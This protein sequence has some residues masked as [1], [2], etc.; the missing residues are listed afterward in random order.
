ML[1]LALKLVSAVFTVVLLVTVTFWI[2]GKSIFANVLQ[3]YVVYT[4]ANF[5]NRATLYLY[6]P[7]RYKSVSIYTS[8]TPFSFR[9][10]SDG[11][12]ALKYPR[13]P[14]ITILDTNSRVQTV[15]D[16]EELFASTHSVLL[17]WSPDA[18][19][20]A[21]YTISNQNDATSA[22]ESVDLYV[23]DKLSRDLI[24][25]TPQNV[26]QA[27]DR[28]TAIWSNDGRLAITV[29][30]SVLEPEIF[31]WDGEQVMNLSQNPSGRDSVL[32]WSYDGQ[33]AFRSS[34]NS[35]D[36]M[37]IWDGSPNTTTF[38][39]LDVLINNTFFREARWTFVNASTVSNG[40]ASELLVW[41]GQSMITVSQ[42]PGS[43]HW[44]V[45]WSPDGW[46]A[47]V[48][49][50]IAGPLSSGTLYIHDENNHL[51]LTTAATYPL[52]WSE[53]GF[54][55]YC[56]AHDGLYLWSGQGNIHHIAS[57]GT[58]AQWQ[59]GQATGGCTSG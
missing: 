42:H 58:Y 18:R 30:F 39:Y 24:N 51:L 35:N 10:A 21:F 29:Y 40:S 48:D 19:H 12:I 14:I 43:H 55:L 27:A 56:N 49:G 13:N 54:L 22:I 41:D 32:G 16:F 11:D 15:L 45:L 38:T 34:R 25:I 6:D 46:T 26:H 1:K 4:Q 53:N 47:Y 59:S 20:L 7:A 33:L 44:S 57:W 37:Y 17:G 3:D 50:L 28:Y 9:S 2:G 5:Q 52:A 23:W 31:I 8:S 36:G